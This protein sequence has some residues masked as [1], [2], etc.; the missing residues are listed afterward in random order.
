MDPWALAAMDRVRTP[1]RVK[2]RSM[3]FAGR[4][5][6]CLLGLRWACAN[7]EPSLFAVDPPQ[8]VSDS[9]LRLLLGEDFIPA[10]LLD[11]RSGR[12]IAT[13]D[14]FSARLGISG[15]WAGLSALDWLSTGM[16]AASL[17]SSA[18]RTL[19][20]GPLDVV[21]TNPR[22]RQ[23]VLPGGFLEAQGPD[24]APPTIA[25]TSPPPGSD[26]VAGD[27]LHGSFHVSESAPTSI[28]TSRGR[29]TK[30]RRPTSPAA[31]RCRRRHAKATALSSSSSAES[32]GVGDS[33]GVVAE[34]TDTSANANRGQADSASR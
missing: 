12:R 13:S 30:G 29:P 3:R 28:G 32:L 4:S 26:F 1:R 5:F 2:M 8:A 6:S 18:A 10:T 33:V 17:P 19:P 15:Q 20:T 9:D 21:L 31:C 22:G 23:A 11:P 14:G 25:F 24:L 7:P 34:A 27:T 16:L